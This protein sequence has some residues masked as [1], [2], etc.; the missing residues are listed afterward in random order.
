[1]INNDLRRIECLKNLDYYS[2]D[3]V[4]LV[5]D[6]YSDLDNERI[7]GMIEH[8]DTLDLEATDEFKLILGE[9]LST[10]HKIDQVI[11][12][13]LSSADYLIPDYLISNEQD[14]EDI[15]KWS[16]Y[17]LSPEFIITELWRRLI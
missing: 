2:Y 11:S 12:R 1:M 3:D 17:G 4:I 16:L 13:R 10:S 7:I 14:R 9:L 15:I 5:F 6:L 8:I